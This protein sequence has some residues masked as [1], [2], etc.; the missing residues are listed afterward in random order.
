MN[1]YSLLVVLVVGHAIASTIGWSLYARACRGAGVPWTFWVKL[2]YLPAALIGGVV[3][4][5][6]PR[7]WIRKVLPEIPSAVP[8]ADLAALSAVVTFCMIWIVPAV[9]V[10]TISAVLTTITRKRRERSRH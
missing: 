3:Y 6:G 2:S 10:S 4:W 7:A 5:I 1:E 8:G 9:A